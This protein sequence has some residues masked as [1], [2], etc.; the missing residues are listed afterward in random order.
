[1]IPSLPAPSGRTL[2]VNPL[3]EDEGSKI[4]FS[5]PALSLRERVSRLVGAGE[6]GAEEPF[7]RRKDS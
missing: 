7:P 6:G 4:S 5:I 1:M 2:G 3:P